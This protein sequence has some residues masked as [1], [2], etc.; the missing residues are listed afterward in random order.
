M[1]ETL[2]TPSE[3]ERLTARYEAAVVEANAQTAALSSWRKY[4]TDEGSPTEQVFRDVAMGVHGALGGSGTVTL[5][6]VGGMTVNAYTTSGGGTVTLVGVGGMT[7]NAYTTSIGGTVNVF[8]A[9]GSG[10]KI[11]PV[12]IVTKI[13]ATQLNQGVR[14]GIGERREERS[15]APAF[16]GRITGPVRSLLAIFDRWQIGDRDAAILLGS[17][18]ISF[19]NDLR[20]GTSGLSTRDMQ[21]RARLLIRIYEGVHSLLREADEE[22]SWINSRLPALDNQTLLDIMRRGSI[23]DLLLVKAY[24]DH[25]NGR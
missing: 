1:R 24:V 21:D 19:V 3:G 14:F 13:A 8:D 18:A 10:V 25:A 12:E 23:S 6:G 2:S 16:R 11:K 15:P 20:V 5:V 7:V 4:F 22:R 17:P 9:S